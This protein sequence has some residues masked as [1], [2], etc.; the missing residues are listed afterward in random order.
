MKWRAMPSPKRQRIQ[1]LKSAGPALRELARVPGLDV[2]LEAL[3][4]GLR[5]RSPRPFSKG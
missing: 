1:L 3:E 2:A 4:V 5:G